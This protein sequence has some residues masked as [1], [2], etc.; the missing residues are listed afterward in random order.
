MKIRSQKLS[1]YLALCSGRNYVGEEQTEVLTEI[2]SLLAELYSCITNH[3][4]G[5]S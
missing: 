2:K 3:L 5:L 4:I 1:D